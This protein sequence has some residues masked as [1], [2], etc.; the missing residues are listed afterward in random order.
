[1]K[2]FMK[3]KKIIIALV[4]IVPGALMIADGVLVFLGNNAMFF[5]VD[6]RFEFFVGLALV[7]LGAKKL[8][9]LEKK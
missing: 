6:S 1:M 9:H 8:K 5:S 7:M 4:L 3:F 2:D